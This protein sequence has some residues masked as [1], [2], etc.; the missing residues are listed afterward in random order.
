MP[1]HSESE[2]ESL[3]MPEIH[4]E[5]EEEHEKIKRKKTIINSIKTN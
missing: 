2:D 1:N 4:F 5:E 3:D